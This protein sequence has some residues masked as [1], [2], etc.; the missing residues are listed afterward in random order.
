MSNFTDAKNWFQMALADIERINRSYNANDFA[1]CAYR[2]QFCG[3]KIIK[4]V[5]LLYGLQ[6]KKLHEVSTI[7]YNEILS[8]LSLDTT[9]YQILENIA[10]NAR[11]IE[12]LSTS[13]LYG[14]IEGGKFTSPEEIYDKTAI[15]EYIVHLLAEIDGLI[16]LFELKDKKDW[17]K[18]K[19]AFQSAQTTLRSL[20]VE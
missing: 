18:Q 6:F 7:L 8:K 3:E 15:N 2:I 16:T 19:E 11:F 1:D 10:S 14:I 4:G 20:V 9:E 12:T 13:P 17:K 5:I